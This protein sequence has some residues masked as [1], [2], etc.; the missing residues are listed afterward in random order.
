MDDEIKK[1]VADEVE[2]EAEAHFGDKA[3]ELADQ[4]LGYF[5][6]KPK[7]DNPDADATDQASPQQ[8]ATSQ[9]D[10]EDDS[11]DDTAEDNDNQ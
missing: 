3:K 9:Q 11:S 5:G 4:A 7:T 6:L 2:T 1:F 10:S 8:P